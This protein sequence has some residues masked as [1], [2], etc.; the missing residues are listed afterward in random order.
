M[1]THVKIIGTDIATFLGRTTGH[2]IQDRKIRMGQNIKPGLIRRM[3]VAARY[4]AGADLPLCCLQGPVCSRSQKLET[5]GELAGGVAHDFNNL[6]A[7]IDGYAHMI[8]QQVE[9]NRALVENLEHIR[10]SV[11]NGASLTRQLLN[12]GRSEAVPKSVFDIARLIKEQT[13]L[14]LPLLNDSIVLEIRPGQERLLVEC[15]ADALLQIVMNLI[16][17]ARD[18]MPS[19]GAIL[20]ALDRIADVDRDYACLS[21]TDS[22]TGIDPAIQERIFDPYFTTK[23]KGKGAGLG[24]ATVRAIVRKWGGRIEVLSRPGKGACVRIFIPLSAKNLPDSVRKTGSGSNAS[25]IHGSTVLVVENE[26]ELRSVLVKTLEGMGAGV[27][28]AANGREALL[29][30]DECDGRINFLLTDVMM[31]EMG[32][33]KLADLV[34]SLWPDVKII[35]MS[36]SVVDGPMARACLPKGASFLAKPVDYDALAKLMKQHCAPKC[37]DTPLLNVYEADAAK[38]PMAAGL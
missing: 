22:G 27:I 5:M 26:P 25:C 17:N 19:G 12:F 24:L 10:L 32:G 38:L 23:E 20:L 6:L 11:K 7:V 31:P 21:V 30:L 29:K 3:F 36:G 2:S 16:V 34:K 37:D 13:A 28:S 9:G 18:A 35:Y 14:L 8:E 15:E 33:I 1:H 4:L